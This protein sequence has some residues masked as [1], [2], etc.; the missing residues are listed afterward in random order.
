MNIQQRRA[1]AFQSLTRERDEAR[2]LLFSIVKQLDGIADEDRTTAE[3]N[4]WGRLRANGYVS[5]S[6]QT[7]QPVTQ[8]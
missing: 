1:R 8:D 5:Q 2:T 3:K 4:I 6:A 7:I